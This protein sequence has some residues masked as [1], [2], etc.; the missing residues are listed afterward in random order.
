MLSQ[1][2]EKCQQGGRAAQERQEWPR[3]ASQQPR[4]AQT[5]QN[6]KKESRSKAKTKQRQSKRKALKSAAFRSQ[7]GRFLGGV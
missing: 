3:A 1:K 5:S 6:S 2:R 4:V 7:L